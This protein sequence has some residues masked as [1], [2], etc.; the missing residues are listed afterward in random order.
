M[1][2]LHILVVSFVA[3]QPSSPVGLLVLSLLLDPSIHAHRFNVDHYLL[4]P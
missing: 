2:D 4:K 1:F 3:R